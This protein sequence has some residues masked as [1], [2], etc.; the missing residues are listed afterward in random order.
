MIAF[1]VFDTIWCDLIFFCNFNNVI[2]DECKT[3]YQQRSL[4]KDLIGHFFNFSIL[5][6]SEINSFLALHFWREVTCF[7]AS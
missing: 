4:S 6:M 2:L 5:R 1:Y 7:K 3:D